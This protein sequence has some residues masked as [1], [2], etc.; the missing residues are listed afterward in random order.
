[1]GGALSALPP[2]EIQIRNI[3]WDSRQLIGSEDTLFIAI[4]GENHDGHEFVSTVYEQ[5]IHTF[6]VQEEWY[7]Q[8]TNPKGLFII[9]KNSLEALHS[10]AKAHRERFQIPIIGITGSNGKTTLKE[11]LS[12]LLRPHFNVC[13]NPKSYNS[14]LGLPLSILQLN[15]SHDLGIFETGISQVGEM[16]ILCDILQPSHAILTNIGAAHDEGFASRSEKLAE[17]LLLLEK[18]G[19]IFIYQR[20]QDTYSIVKK[21]CPEAKAIELGQ[22][23]TDFLQLLQIEIQDSFTSIQLEK[24]G[25]KICLQLPFTNE[26]A[27][28]NGLQ[29]ILIYCYFRRE[30]PTAQLQRELQQGLLQ[31]KSVP[32]R[33]EII[34]GVYQSSIIN[35]TYNNDPDA[36]AVALQH[37]VR[38]QSTGK[39]VL[40]LS[41]LMQIDFKAIDQ[42]YA[43]LAKLIILSKVDQFIGIGSA[44]LKLKP[45]LEKAL[46][47]CTFYP[48]KEVF[49][50]QFNLRQ[51]ERSSVLVKGARAFAFEDLVDFLAAKNHRTTL[52][53]NLNAIRQNLNVYK[54]SIK[55][56]TKLLVM[57]KAEAYGGGDI[58]IAKMLEQEY[59]DY[60]GVAYV[61]EGIKLR[62]GGIQTP[63]LVLNAAVDE[64]EQ[65]IRYNLE[66]EMHNLSQFKHF[67]SLTDQSLKK[68]GFHLKL[69][70]GMHRLGFTE[71]G[72]DAFIQVY[73]EAKNLV[74]RSAMSHLASS[75]QANHDEFTLQQIKRFEAMTS[76]L[77]E[78][79]PHK[80]DRHILN[81]AGIERFNQHQFEMVRLGL[82][83]YGVSESTR[84]KEKLN[85][86]FALKA[87]V[88]AIH[89]VQ[90]SETIGYNRQGK[91]VEDSLI[92]TVSIGYAD[93]FLRKAGNGRFSLKISGKQYPVVGNICMDMCMLN[94]NGE[95]QVQVND[96][97]II[98]D[99]T[100]EL[101]K[102]SQAL[103]TI[104]YEAL[105]NISSRVRRKY[106]QD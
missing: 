35:D 105:T 40:I 48:T 9:V 1:M 75:D 102:L 83:L 26:A 84:F 81:T 77:Q 50:T 38:H 7:Q 62:K 69:E 104:P 100:S 29:A 41:D 37:L 14:K 57:I 72:L 34:D 99:Q 90:A 59:V 27:I 28:S 16:N 44:I 78:Q 10:L 71:E 55:S 88:T 60:F 70:T 36:L 23:E 98:F 21:S 51:L 42:V 86:A 8:Q 56:S 3:A 89:A 82:G 92:A 94:L 24:G 18:A 20:N 93:G 65:C 53:I 11:W 5:G 63:I 32:M 73:A 64:L 97:V 15:Q 30:I 43:E 101:E 19:H 79:I 67:K 54:A 61:D 6:L 103:E 45:A 68:H 52:E 49:K 76:H 13:K 91:L 12:I 87:R 39:K 85:L 31:I 66:P 4:K 22:K 47:D 74:L 106:I 17:K 80:F 46:I 58:E 33:L 95:Q 25:E 96:E 2:K